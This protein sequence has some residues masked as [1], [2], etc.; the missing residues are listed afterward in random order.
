M[1]LIAN[2]EP[3]PGY[4]LIERLGRGGYGEVWKAEAPG[5]MLKAIKFVYGNL[6]EATEN[7]KP[8]EQE[9]KALNR[10]K[11][12]RHPFILSLERIDVIDGQLVIVME[13]ADRNLFDRF[14]EC[15][16]QGLPGIPR[17]ELLRYMEETAEALDLMNSQ[18]QIQHMD[19]KPQ[20]IF[21][22][23]QHIKIA[24]FGLA[25][26]LEG[27]NATLTGGVTPVYAAP[28]TFEARVTRFCDQYSLAIVYQELLTGERPFHGTTAR[29]LMMQHLQ[30]VPDLSPLPPHDRPIVA[31]ALAKDPNQRYP[32]CA[33]MVRALI[34][35]GREQ[36]SESHPARMTPAKEAASPGASVV[37]T[38]RP[39]TKLPPLRTKPASTSQVNLGR[40][41]TVP[42]LRLPTPCDHPKRPPMT[43]KTGPGP[44]RPA[45]VIGLGQFGLFTLQRLRRTIRE[46]FDAASLPH[47]KFLYIDTESE[48][49]Q[50]IRSSSSSVEDDEFLLARLQRSSYYQQARDNLPPISDWL[51][52]ATLFRIPKQPAT[53]GIRALGRLALCDHYRAIMDHVQQAIEACTA[54]ESLAQAAKQTGLALRSNYPRVYIVTSLMGGTGSGMFLDLAY[55]V[56]RLLKWMGFRALEVDGLLFLPDTKDESVPRQALANAHAA[57]R[58]LIHFSLPNTQYE[59]LLDPKDGLL[60]D[61]EPPFRR[62]ALLPLKQMDSPST[63]RP[64]LGLAA[65]FL[66]QELLTDMGREADRARGETTRQIVGLPLQTFGTFRLLW[67]QRTILEQWARTCCDDIL[68]AWSSREMTALAEPLAQWVKG[69]LPALQLDPEQLET[70][71]DEAVQRRNDGPVRK[72]LEEA[73]ADEGVPA[74]SSSEALGRMTQRFEWV[75]ATVGAPQEHSTV[76][77]SRIEGILDLTA[78]ELTKAIRS[79]LVGLVPLLVDQPGWR[80]AGA[81][82]FCRQIGEWLQK[83]VEFLMEDLRPRRA[84]V[85]EL[86]VKALAKLKELEG[87]GRTSRIQALIREANRQLLTFA[88]QQYD[89]SRRQAVISILSSLTSFGADE[90]RDLRAV[91]DRLEALQQRI[92]RSKS[93][94]QHNWFG[95]EML[96][97]PDGFPSLDEAVAT[98]K[99]QMTP[100]HWAELEKR[101]Q[102][103]LLSAHRSLFSFFQ[104][105]VSANRETAQCLIH[106]ARTFLETSWSRANIAEIL[107]SEQ[108]RQYATPEETLRDAFHEAEPML[109]VSGSELVLLSVPPGEMGQKLAQKATVALGRYDV[110]IV[111]GSNEEVVIHREV[112]TIPANDL[113]LLGKI[114]ERAFSEL[115]DTPGVT[116]HSRSDVEWATIQTLSTQ[117]AVPVIPQRPPMPNSQKV[118]HR[119]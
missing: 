76:G 38:N 116:P 89:L 87:Q 82:E 40:A 92:R 16:L 103:R 36:P 55:S 24:D 84:T 93:G 80:V 29:Q 34:A 30:A 50:S 117:G 118:Q 71:L 35:A 5:G 61:S 32:S 65:G 37:G 112:Q 11:S 46:R 18:F 60:I 59:A 68:T 115:C 47:L 31:R 49:L 114:G 51:P 56:R 6:D 107:L 7:G 1:R 25:K 81:E 9:L 19:I 43:E 98:L 8:A 113:E 2:A 13:L 72:L 102:T 21:L 101:L 74:G 90:A 105:P 99:Q 109:R 44:L 58:E 79:K 95:P 67:P 26:D 96:I 23:F 83:V 12:I 17:D 78:K 28:E 66:Y 14:R 110:G 57:L 63:M 97:L 3:I 86:F 106:E 39:Q 52:A 119:D 10:V 91:R 54:D 73:L 48:T 94:S 45:L 77:V 41:G 4:R 100:E 53:L 75:L 70:A 62:C 33:E 15:Q 27:M 108:S 111:S 85:Q 69:Q 22:V 88:I 64:I 42:N 104:D 20:N